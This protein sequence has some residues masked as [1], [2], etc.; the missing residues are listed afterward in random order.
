MRLHLARNVG[1]NSRSVKC[2]S[3]LSEN[4]GTLRVS[5]YNR[6]LLQTL[7]SANKEKITNVSSTNLVSRAS[8]YQ[9]LET[10]SASVHCRSLVQHPDQK[11]DM[12]RHDATACAADGTIDAERFK[13]A[14]QSQRHVA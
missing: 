11:H 8:G 14:F 5:S 4:G 9:P 13:G 2:H 10:Y 3:E 6:Y 12:A 1:A 7:Q